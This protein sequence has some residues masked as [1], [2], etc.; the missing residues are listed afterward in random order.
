MAVRSQMYSLLCTAQFSMKVD[1][2]KKMKLSRDILK[3]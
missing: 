1:G 2:R 3:M